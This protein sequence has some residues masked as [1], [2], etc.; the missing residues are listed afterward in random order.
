MFS[1]GPWRI[2]PFDDTTHRPGRAVPIA[3]TIDQ[4]RITEITVRTSDGPPA[5]A[6]L[7]QPRRTSSSAG[8]HTI[9]EQS[10]AC[11]GDI[12]REVGSV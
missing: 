5:R 7:L 8:G 1:A 2:C 9:N 4:P 11:H 3:G 6:N 12:H 10:V